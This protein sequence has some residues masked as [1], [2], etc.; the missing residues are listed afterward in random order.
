MRFLTRAAVTV[1]LLTAKYSTPAYTDDMK[2]SQNQADIRQN[3]SMQRTMWTAQWVTWGILAV[4]VILTLLGFFG[5][6]GPLSDKTAANQTVAVDYEAFTRRSAPTQL[7]I[8]V[9]HPAD[10]VATLLVQQQ[11]L[12]NYQIQHI[13]PQPDSVSASGDMV[14]YMFNVPPGATTSQIDFSLQTDRLTV[15]NVSGFIGTDPDQLVKI[16][17]VVYP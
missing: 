12:E 9:K 8:T 15:G 14:T 2:L 1:R 10:G 17:Q 11:L 4:L 7:T 3:L 13:S 16:T 6:A 5:G